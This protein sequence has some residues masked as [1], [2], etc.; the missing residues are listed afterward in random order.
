MGMKNHETV[1]TALVSQIASL[2]HGG[3]H[4]VLRELV[5]NKLLVYDNNRNGKRKLTQLSI[6]IHFCPGTFFFIGVRD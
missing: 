2:K 1:P 6:Y 4:K 5:K 3:C